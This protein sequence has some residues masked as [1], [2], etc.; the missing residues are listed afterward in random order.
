MQG[1]S[2]AYLFDRMTINSGEEQRYG[3]QFSNAYPIKKIVELAATEDVANMEKR[4]R[5]I[6]LMTMVICNKLMLINLYN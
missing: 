3:T 5:E 2:Y 6:G 1:Q 4:R